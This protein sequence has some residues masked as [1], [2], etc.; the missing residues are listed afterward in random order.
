M[1]I[2]VITSWPPEINGISDYSK[3]LYEA[4]ASITPRI[5]IRIKIYARIPGDL[6]EVNTSYS[7]SGSLEVEYSWSNKDPLYL[8]KL[9][10][11]IMKDNVEIVH[12]QYE[13]WLYGRGLKALLL[14][15]LLALLRLMKKK[16]VVTLHGLLVLTQL[17]RNFKKFHKFNA[18]IY[19]FKIFSIIYIRILSALSNIIVVHLHLMK[20]LLKHQYGV[21]VEKIRVIPHGILYIGTDSNINQEERVTFTV[22]GSI[23]P[24]K[25][26]EKIL[27]AFSKLVEAH[28]NVELVIAGQYD[29]S[30][31]P[32]ASGYLNVIWNAVRRFNLEKHVVLKHNLPFEEVC[33]IYQKSYAVILN[34]L[35]KSIVAASGPLALAFAFAKPAIV[36]KIPRFFEYRYF[37]LLVDP[38]DVDEIAKSMKTLIEDRNLYSSLT[39]KLEALRSIYSWRN[40][41][42]EHLY[43]YVELAR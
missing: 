9:L 42:R 35:D 1:R 23:R 30:I 27:E 29:P 25:G 10:K 20:E 5:K 24:D 32:E 22:F 3:Q 16:V 11:K 19:L 37:T 41:A 4:L 26:I 28:G 18:P 38:E 12:V 6:R 14:P 34:Y 15:A 39:R 17:D 8:F 7:Q 36:S 13:Y 21:N 33:S 31:S 40:I 2:G 43:M